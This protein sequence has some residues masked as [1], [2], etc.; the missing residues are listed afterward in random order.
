MSGSVRCPVQ[1]KTC[2]FLSTTTDQ[3]LY[4]AGMLVDHTHGRL[5]LRCEID[6]LC[7]NFTSVGEY[8]CLIFVYISLSIFRGIEQKIEIGIL[9]LKIKL[10]HFLTVV[11]LIPIRIGNRQGIVKFILDSVRIIGRICIFLIQDILDLGILCCIYFKSAAVE[12]IGC[13]FFG[14][15]FDIH[16]VVDD[17]ICQFIFKI[18]VNSILSAGVL[19][20]SGLDTGINIICKSFIILILSNIV[21]I[22]HMLENFL[23]SLPVAVRI[24]NRVKFRR[25][26]CDTCQSC[27]FRKIQIPYILVKILSC[28]SLYTVGT[29]TQ[30]NCVQVILKNGVFI[31]FFLNLDSKVL[32]LDFSRKSFQLSR[33]TGPVGKYVIL[34]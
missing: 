16:Q 2:R 21:L 4:I 6:T 18:C 34:K 28:G 31:S 5:W 32:F 7:K 23:A 22:Q 25:V 1:C 26:L 8:A 10:Q 9:I 33:F 20:L 3:S 30:V 12:K 15:T 11:Y 14:V 19:F 29:G 24:D 27:T 13:L 17:L